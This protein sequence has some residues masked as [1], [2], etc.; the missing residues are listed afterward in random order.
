MKQGGRGEGRGARGML[1]GV[2]V[3]GLA[4]EWSRS[5]ELEEVKE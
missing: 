1:W 3:E 5:R 4:G 2:V